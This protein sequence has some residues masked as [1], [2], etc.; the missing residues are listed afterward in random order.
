MSI[1]VIATVKVLDESCLEPYSEIASPLVEKYGGEYVARTS[2]P[3]AV[4]GS[5][6]TDRDT[7]IMRWPSRK[8]F[9]TFWDSPE[10]AVAKEIRRGKV[11]LNNVII[12][13]ET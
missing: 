10:Y 4:E 7:V 12:E 6:P 9:M 1:H 11:E 3:E 2:N 13:D 8:V 5:W